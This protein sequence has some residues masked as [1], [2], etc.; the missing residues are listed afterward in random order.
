MRLILGI[1]LT[2][3]VALHA[4]SWDTLRGLRPGD[5]V[6][7]YE[8]SGQKHQGQF[9]GFSA[10]AITLS[11]NGTQTPFERARVR[12]VQV[13]SG[14]RRVRRML[15]GVGIGVAVGLVIDQTLGAVFRNETG[16]TTGE[17]ALTYVVPA[18][19]FGAIFGA[20]P[21]Y[22]TVYRM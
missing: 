10:D 12:R 2:A 13:R 9:A 15:I 1:L 19:V 16:E 7:V 14:S 6:R 11:V 4:Q 17:R 5:S 3:A 22:R 18:G 20:F 21:A 8:T